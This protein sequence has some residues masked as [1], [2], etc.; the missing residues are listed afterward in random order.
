MPGLLEPCG[1]WQ[2]PQSSATGAC[3]QRYGPRFS[4]WQSKQVL[5]QS[6]RA[7]CRSLRRAVSAVAAAAVH[8][9]LPDRM[10]IRLHRLRSLLLVAV[11]AHFRLCRCHQHRIRGGVTGMAIGAGNVIHVV[12]VAVPAEARHRM[13]GNPCK[14]RFA[15]RPVCR[16]SGP[17]MAPGAG[18]S[19]PRRTR[20]A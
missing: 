19:S 12:V 17:K 7:N 11:E 13:Y 4:A 5:I 10:R 9:A 1:S 6:C 18:R 8:L 14:V 3:S 20:P 2:L 15:R 16:G